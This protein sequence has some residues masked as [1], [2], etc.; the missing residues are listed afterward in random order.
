VRITVSCALFLF[1]AA[2]ALYSQSIG[3]GTI[4]GTVTDPSGA[5][6]SGAAV[7]IH[8]PVT[9]YEQSETTDTAGAFRFQNVPLNS[10]RLEV[11]ANG[12]Q[13]YDR[14]V[15]VQTVVPIALPVKLAIAGAATSINVEASAADLVENV[16]VAHNDVD[17]NT[18][19]KLPTTSPASGLS[20][21]I[22]MSAPGVVADSNGF[23]HPLGDHA[24][25]SYYVDGQP[26][27][28]QQSKSFSTQLPDNAFQSM[29][30]ITGMAPAQYGDKTSLVVDAVTRSGLGRKPFGSFEAQ[31]GSFGSISE[32][33]SVGWGGNKAGNFLVAN[34]VRSGR[35]LDTPEFWPIHDAG[36]NVTLFDRA[37]Y[38]PTTSD[39]FH[40]DLFLAR[41][42]FQ[43][44]NTYD[45][46]NQDQRQQVVSFNIA[47]GYQHTFGASMLL[48]VNPWARRDD[49][50][51]YPSGDPFADTPATL[52]QH[53]TL[54]NWGTR[55]DLSIVKGKHNLKIGTELKQ[56]R[57]DES[58]SLGIT[59]F[60]FNPVCL[61]AA[62]SAAGPAAI[63]N[64]A[65][66][67]AAG[68]APN[69]NMLP[70]L[71]PF[72]LTRGGTPLQFAD[73][74]NVNQ[75]AVY[76]QDSVT[77]GNWTL[78]G[79]LRVDR[80]SGL[81][82]D[83][84]AEPRA[85]FSYLVKP[86]G[87]VLRGSYARTMETP[88]NE[89]LLLSS[90]SGVGGLAT[91]VFGALAST[92]LRP[93]RRNQ[94][95]TG[96]QQAFGKYLVVDGDYF[97]K[98]TDNA[99]DFDVLFNTPIAF[100]ISWTRSKLDGV[101]VRVSTTSIKG[102]QAYVT[103]GHSRARYFPPENG[104]LIFNSPVGAGVFRIDHDQAFE[105]TMNLRYQR[106]KNGPWIDFTWR[107]DSGLV[108]GA[109][110]TLDNVLALTGA[111]Q[112]AIGF[113]C[114]SQRP[115]VGNPI[116][117]CNAP[118]GAARVA[119]PA[120]GTENDD[121]NPPRIAPHHV[122]DVAVGTDNLLHTEPVH[123]TLR[124]TVLNLTNE[125]ALYNFLSTFSGTH[126]M[127]PRAYYASVG[128]NF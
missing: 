97:W 61:D 94:F 126:F 35:F 122:F 118:Y 43:V 124:L 13:I 31:Y 48:T 26:I 68:F 113:Y 33:G 110:G 17:T 22:T 88:Y 59:D 120:P 112:A 47:P 30:L 119:I 105:Q 66:C 80:Y 71:V 57:L 128:V 36:N 98:Y 10:Y 90:A 102:F 70:G 101:G 104:G 77:L 123:M 4:T 52:G 40:L 108:A 85:G 54:L 116:T 67:A 34:S 44:P 109:V 16:P 3:A 79:G 45:Q 41:N 15:N 117:S 121:T 53:R 99:Y 89:N 103:M 100:P 60:T 1:A 21:A 125:V 55:A 106:P 65:G 62:G 24:E 64:P 29:E 73:A 5:A 37:D 46:P 76:V 38:Q 27:N 114:G 86:T 81:S 12:F 51:Y 107:Y 20:D 75:A 28:D 14:D 2:A 74:G 8:N 83:T 18:L 82:R 78:Q 7:T 11:Q 32:K 42:W 93:G 72:D 49:V 6:V 69:P 111:E 91:N 95:N 84:A 92:P 127:T 87:T 56:T 58:F 63:T 23:F 19:A 39:A 50:H 115:G 9:N 25:T 96:L